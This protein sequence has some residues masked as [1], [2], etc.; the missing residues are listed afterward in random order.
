MKTNEEVLKMKQV[1]FGAFINTEDSINKEKLGMILATLDWVLEEEGLTIL[2]T[3]IKK[4][5]EENK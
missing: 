5:R 2:Q 1:A 4:C 3:R